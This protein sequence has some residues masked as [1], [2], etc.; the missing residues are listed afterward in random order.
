MHDGGDEMYEMNLVY[1]MCPSRGFFFLSSSLMGKGFLRFSAHWIGH[2]SSLFGFLYSPQKTEI[3]TFTIAINVMIFSH[4][5]R[6][7]M[8]HDVRD[9]EK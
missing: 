3:L 7:R 1:S 4:I 2:L 6:L 5:C 8:E 9:M